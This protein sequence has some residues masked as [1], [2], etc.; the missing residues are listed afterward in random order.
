[1]KPLNRGHRALQSIAASVEDAP[2][3]MEYSVEV[4]GQNHEYQGSDNLRI[5]WKLLDFSV[6][7]S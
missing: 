3:N 1:M 4:L 7:D 5:I 6:V 2:W